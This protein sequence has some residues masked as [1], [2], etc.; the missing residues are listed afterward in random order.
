MCQA[1]IDIQQ[2]ARKEGRKEGW[3]EGRN[4]GRKEGE[5]RG[6]KRGVKLGEMKALVA[7]VRAI[8][9]RFEVSEEEAMKILRVPKAKRE[10]VREQLSKS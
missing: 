8:I 10:A 6:E 3:K 4:E 7:S 9:K 5:K 1:I 2:I